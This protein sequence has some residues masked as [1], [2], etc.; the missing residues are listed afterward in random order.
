MDPVGSPEL[1]PNTQQQLAVQSAKGA[2]SG[3]MKLFWVVVVAMVV[4]GLLVIRFDSFFA[5]QSYRYRV[6][7]FKERDVEWDG[8]VWK[9]GGTVEYHIRVPI[10]E[11]RRRRH[12]GPARYSNAYPP[13]QDVIDRADKTLRFHLSF[14]ASRLDHTSARAH[15]RR[16]ERPAVSGATDPLKVIGTHEFTTAQD[17]SDDFIQACIP[18]LQDVMRQYNADAKIVDAMVLANIASRNDDPTTYPGFTGVALIAAASVMGITGFVVQVSRQ[19][20]KQVHMQANSQ[21]P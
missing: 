11:Q 20:K 7:S 16:V 15:F 9:L 10:P 13:P 12:A 17:A 6:Y 5:T 2:S 18:V 4:A 3:L 14:L 21:R 19:Y 8:A 1:P